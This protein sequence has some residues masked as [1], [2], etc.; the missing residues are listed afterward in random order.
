MISIVL[1]IILKLGL[2]G[3]GASVNTLPML[4]KIMHW[5]VV[6]QLLNYNVIGGLLKV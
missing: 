1:Q 6:E 2:S 5:C 4:L 3:V